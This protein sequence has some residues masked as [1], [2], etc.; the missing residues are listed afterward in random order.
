MFENYQG[1]SFNDFLTLEFRKS[2]ASSPPDWRSSRILT[3]ITPATRRE[4]K[5]HLLHTL[6]FMME[7]I[8]TVPCRSCKPMCNPSSLLLTGRLCC[9]IR[10][11]TP[12]RHVITRLLYHLALQGLRRSRRDVGYAVKA[13]IGQTYMRPIYRD[14]VLEVSGQG[15]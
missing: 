8:V 4:H 5:E 15:V 13:T 10:Q 6:G 11:H 3:S 2:S 14:G 7:I 9:Q 1:M 12:Y